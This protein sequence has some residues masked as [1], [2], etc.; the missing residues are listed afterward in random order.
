VTSVHS[1]VARTND[2]R[3]GL[4]R[5]PISTTNAAQPAGA[6]SPGNSPIDV[7]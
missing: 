1:S 5:T 7:P 3:A 2:V 6:S 4:A